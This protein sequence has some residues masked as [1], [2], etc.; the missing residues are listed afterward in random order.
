[1]NTDDLEFEWD[2][3]KNHQNILKHAIDF[4]DALLVW[5][6]PKRQERFGRSHSLAEDR[7][8]TVG[9]TRFGLLFV[10][11]CERMYSDGAFTLRLISAR[12]AEPNEVAAYARHTFS[13]GF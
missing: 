5:E 8:Q 11:Y 10:V 13:I 4:E 9:L 3:E 12:L 7:W 1:M 6:D 2:E